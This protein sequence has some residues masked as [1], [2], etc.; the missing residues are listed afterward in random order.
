MRVRVPLTLTRS[1]GRTQIL[2]MDT[3]GH[4]S[5]H[6][7]VPPTRS[8]FFFVVPSHA[9]GFAPRLPVATPVPVSGTGT[10][11]RT[12]EK[13]TTLRKHIFSS[14][15]SLLHPPVHLRQ[16]SAWQASRAWKNSLQTTGFGVRDGGLRGVEGGRTEPV[17]LLRMHL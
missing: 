12:K 13:R 4:P 17:G 15:L 8:R 10:R 9:P 11:R 16:L 3:V 1:A 2:E 6:G 7:A 14:C 5:R